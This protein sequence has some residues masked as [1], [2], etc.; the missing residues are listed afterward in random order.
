LIG[1]KFVIPFL[2]GLMLKDWNVGQDERGRL[3]Q[4]KDKEKQEREEQE[5]ADKEDGH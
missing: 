4:K 2:M 1:L 5:E 3:A